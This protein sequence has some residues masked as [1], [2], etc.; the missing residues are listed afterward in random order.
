MA[1]AKV[2]N[3]NFYPI[4]HNRSDDYIMA[5]FKTE[6]YLCWTPDKFYYMLKLMLENLSLCIALVNSKISNLAF[7]QHQKI[8][9]RILIQV[10]SPQFKTIRKLPDLTGDSKSIK[11]IK[12]DFNIYFSLTTYI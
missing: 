8:W 9:G 12:G 4:L 7:L 10:L 5:D 6:Y 1:L 11:A 2:Q 3:I